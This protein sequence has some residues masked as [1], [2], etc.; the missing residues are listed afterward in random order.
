MGG[1]LWWLRER[2]YLFGNRTK[3]VLGAGV[4]ALVRR[5][6]VAVLYM[7]GGGGAGVMVIAWGV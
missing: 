1:G 5:V 2:L 7:Y 6:I 4:I 3:V